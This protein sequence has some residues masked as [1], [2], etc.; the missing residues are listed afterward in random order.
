MNLQTVR[1]EAQRL[2]R[3]AAQLHA[4]V[5]VEA[6]AR[7]LGLPIFSKD[8]GDV[9]ALLVMPGGGAPRIVVNAN[10]TLERRRFSIGHELGHAYLVH[11]FEPGEH[12]HVDRGTLVMARGAA[13]ATGKDPM[14]REANAFAAALLMP[15]ELVEAELE[16]IKGNF[17]TEADIESMASH[18]RVSPQAMQFHL[19][20]LH[21]VR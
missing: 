3:E 1:A 9:S 15:P 20:N 17:V 18:F 8:L 11:Q 21:M 14:E 4:P 5:D 2:L 12:V 16:K 10:H 7:F 19:Q 6:V 13:A